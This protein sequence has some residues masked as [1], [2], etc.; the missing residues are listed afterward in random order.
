M[1]AMIK[2]GYEQKRVPL[3]EQ[4][5]LNT[6]FTLYIDPSHICNFRCSYCTQAWTKEEKENIQF[7]EQFMDKHT[8]ESIKKQ[9]LEFDGRFKML[10]IT[11]LGEPLANPD[12]PKMIEW[13]SKN[14]VSEKI[15]MYTNGIL[16][17]SEKTHELVNAGLTK[18]RISIQ[19]VHAEAYRK[20]AEVKIDFE[21]L[22]ENIKYFYEHRENCKLYIKVIDSCLDEGEKDEFYRIFGN[23]CDEI[24]IEH[25]VLAQHS[26]GDYQGKVN[27]NLTLY[28][29]TAIEKK[30][31]PLMFYVLQI[32]A[33]GN[34]VPCTPLG[35]PSSF[36]L[37]NVN[38]TTL[39]KIWQGEKLQNLRVQNLKGDLNEIFVCS[40]CDNY[41]CITHDSD[42]LDQ[43]GEILLNKIMGETK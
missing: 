25:L 41:N 35:L 40:Q 20:N 29:E 24:F 8:F 9:V 4:I 13:F 6:P 19:G 27:S 30:I 16:L 43:Y 37:G 10:L 33:V 31:C 42:N 7:K 32:D 15:E 23:I 22:V 12:T 2:P 38:E 3:Y 26:M 28:G 36:S 5:P 14:R 21:K 18:L 1:K 11:G 34:V 17:T 39:K